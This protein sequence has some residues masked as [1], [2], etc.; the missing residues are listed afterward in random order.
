MEYRP[1]GRTGLHV[2]PLVLGTDKKAA[3]TKVRT[4]KVTPKEP[5]EVAEPRTTEINLFWGMIKIKR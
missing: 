5:V 4:K 2:S 3:P 1:F